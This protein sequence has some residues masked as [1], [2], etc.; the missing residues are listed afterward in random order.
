MIQAKRAR[1][2]GTSPFINGITTHNVLPYLSN[3]NLTGLSLDD[4]RNKI[5]RV[6]Q[7]SFSNDTIL[8][9]DLAGGDGLVVTLLNVMLSLSRYSCERDAKEKVVKETR[10]YDRN[11]LQL[12]LFRAK[13]VETD[14]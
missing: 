10:K 13:F 12:K 1:K 9:Y 5:Y 11:V 6:I 8:L 2:Q 4:R 7:T 3:W 14:C